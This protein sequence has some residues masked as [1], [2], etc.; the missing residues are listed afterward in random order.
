MSRY[1]LVLLVSFAV[2]ALASEQ[3]SNTSY[4]Q[5]AHVKY[6]S[7]DESLDLGSGISYSSNEPSATD[8]LSYSSADPN[9]DKGFGIKYSS[10][11]ASVSD[12]INYS[13]QDSPS[14]D[15]HNSQN[16]DSQN[17][18]SQDQNGQDNE[19]PKSEL[20]I[21]Y[22]KL[23]ASYEAKD[24]KSSFKLAQKICAIDCYSEDLNLVMGDSAK[25]LGLDDDALAAF[26][27]VT[28]ISDTNITAHLEIAQLYQKKGNDELLK[29]E[30]TSLLTLP[31]DEAQKRYIEDTLEALK[32]RERQ[33]ERSPFYGSFS[34]S[35]GWDSNPK[36]NT[37]KRKVY[38]P[39]IQNYAQA[40][41]R[42]K[43][44][45]Y[46]SS[47]LNAGLDLMGD[48]LGLNL[49]L[50][51]NTKK[52]ALKNYPDSSFIS[53][54]L[55]PSI[56]AGPIRLS[57]GAN[58]DHIYS[59]SKLYQRAWGLNA[60]VDLYI[61]DEHSLNLAYN[62]S[63]SKNVRAEID[64]STHLPLPKERSKHSSYSG[65]YSQ[66]LE[67]GLW[68]LRLSWDEER[69]YFTDSD[70]SD[71]KDFSFGT[72]LNYKLLSSLTGKMSFSYVRSKYQKSNYLFNNS[73]R[74][75]K[76]YGMSLGAD[77]RFLK[78]HSLGLDL[79]YKRKLS[80]QD[81]YSYQ[82]LMPSLTYRVRF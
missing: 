2:S 14:Q 22:E 62:I 63:K 77:Y 28:V 79:N 70:N 3:P 12:G 35:L 74:A 32:N 58:Y 37:L 8:G 18:H 13:S 81:S 24:Y 1:S 45:Y 41:T 55:A 73:F 36:H 68:Y 47:S 16:Q 43:P 33:T 75:D 19:D 56:G 69:G 27:R 7:A 71:Y 65:N 60:S 39:F 40:G 53:L 30:L 29:A 66:Y 54:S 78:S 59:E 46:A 67:D 80:N 82:Q 10:A 6:S 17:S 23:A 44:S 49:D 52:F 51:A 25:Q 4:E 34:L 76:T 31:L 15:S 21:L 11:D 61:G 72:G 50:Y 20:A 57:T 42:H 26:D 9:T 38:I 48:L 5:L 64:E